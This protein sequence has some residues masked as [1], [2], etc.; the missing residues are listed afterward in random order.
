MTTRFR[1]YAVTLSH[2]PQLAGAVTTAKPL[3]QAC[4]LST[5]SN[6]TSILIT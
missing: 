1:V 2:A 3:A 4:P 5:Y 6:R